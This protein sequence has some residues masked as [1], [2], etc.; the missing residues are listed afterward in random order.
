MIDFMD[1]LSPTTALR[2]VVLKWDRLYGDLICRQIVA[3]WP[4]AEV[5]V[6]QR[7]FD[8]LTSIQGSMPDLFITGVKIE[9][10][11]GL[12]HLEP[13]VDKRLPILI[14][15]SRADART[16]R[17]LKALR[18]DGIYDGLAEGLDNLPVALSRAIEHQTYISPSVMQ[19]L[20]HPRAVTLDELTET[21]QV[22]LSVIGDGCDDQ[23]ASERLGMSR[24]TMKTH[25]KVIMRKLRLHHKGQLMLYALQQGYVVVT[26][27][28]IF[29]PGFERR[30]QGPAARAKP[31]NS[32]VKPAVLKVVASAAMATCFL[33]PKLATVLCAA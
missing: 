31:A 21:E 26:P 4:K 19:H 33:S 18:Y 3:F 8:A 24:Q 27:G 20:R 9:D 25:R 10:M 17:M 6:F 30:I 23:V 29:R 1:T 2:V 15:T 11:D 16:F 12:E 32:K 28:G 7:G 13:F 14:L 22:V 5:K